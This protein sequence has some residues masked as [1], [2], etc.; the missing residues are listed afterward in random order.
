MA[1]K[2]SYQTTDGMNQSGGGNA[3]GSTARPVANRTANG[4]VQSD[5]GG[6]GDR[7]DGAIPESVSY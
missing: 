2:K 4:P 3:S 7:K 1:S 5:N 6:K